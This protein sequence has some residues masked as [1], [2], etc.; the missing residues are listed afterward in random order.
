MIQLQIKT[1]T[2]FSVSDDLAIGI[3]GTILKAFAEKTIMDVAKVKRD[4]HRD[5]GIVPTEGKN[6]IRC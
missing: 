3:R 6:K 1:L 2:V 4:R 5:G